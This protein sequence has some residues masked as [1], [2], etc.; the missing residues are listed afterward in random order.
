[1]NYRATT[2]TEGPEGVKWEQ[3]LFLAREMGFHAL[4]LGF[5]LSANRQQRM[6]LK[7]GNPLRRWENWAG[8]L[9]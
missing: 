5:D 1:M 7:F 3:G 2:Y 6:G 8:K 4:G 9:E